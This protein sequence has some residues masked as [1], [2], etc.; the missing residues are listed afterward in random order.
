MVLIQVHQL[1]KSV[2][3]RV[4]LDELS[5]DIHEGDKIGLVGWN[6]AGK[7][8]LVKILMGL[9]APDTGTVKKIPASLSIGYLPQSTEQLSFEGELNESGETL[10]KSASQ[11][12]LSKLNWIDSETKYLSGGE[13]LKLSLAKIWANH[14]QCLLLDEP[15]N[16]LDSKGIN[17]LINEVKSYNIL[18]GKYFSY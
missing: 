1:K 13:K 2:G 15:T 18:K 17:W 9:V 6:G 7:T 14:S 11:L 10:L 16:H 5:F 3:T 4:I 12:G 8:T